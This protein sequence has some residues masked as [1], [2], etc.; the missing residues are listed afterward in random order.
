MSSESVSEEAS[1]LWRIKS[2]H[3]SS[4]RDED[5]AIKPFMLPKK[6]QEVRARKMKKRQAPKPQAGR[7]KSS[8]WN[9]LQKLNLLV[10]KKKKK[11]KT[12]KIKLR[13]NN[14]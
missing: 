11:I 5:E 9:E 7:K 3:N 4:L 6:C 8:L 12:L 10:T 1:L 2:K 13:R 14:L